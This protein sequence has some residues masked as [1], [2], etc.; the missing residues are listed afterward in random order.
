M[1]SRRRTAYCWSCWSTAQQPLRRVGGLLHACKCNLGELGVY[2]GEL[3]EEIT[4]STAQPQGALLTLRERFTLGALFTL[5]ERAAIQK[6]KRAS[7][8]GA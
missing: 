6:C 5:G 7:A 8:E 3:N 2:L 4:S 1:T